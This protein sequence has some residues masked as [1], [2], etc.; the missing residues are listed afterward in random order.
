MHIVSECLGN[1]M[2]VRVGPVAG[3]LV[4]AAGNN[5]SIPITPRLASQ[6]GFSMKEDIHGTV[7]IFASLQ[8]CFAQNQEDVAFTTTL[9]ID[10][11]RDHATL[12]QYKVA[13]TCQYAAWAT[14]EILCDRNYM[15]VSVRRTT[16]DAYALPE[17]PIY[18]N[19]PSDQAA[20]AETWHSDPGMRIKSIVFHSTVHQEV[21]MTVHDAQERGYGIALTPT[22]LVLRSPSETH[23]T[24]FEDV[25]GVPMTVLRT[26]TF[27]QKKWSV[28]QID[29]QAACPTPNGGVYFTPNMITWY[30]PTFIDPLISS[31]KFNLV[32]VHMG[33]DGRRLDAAQMA[34]RQ[35]SMSVGDIYI[36]ITIPVGA[37]GGYF[38]SYVLNGQ[39]FTTYTIEPMLE[40]VWTE[41][42]T[43]ED[44]RY[45]VLFPI[46]TPM[47][48]GPIQVIDNTI[49]EEKIFKLSLGPMN[50]DVVLLNITFSNVVLSVHDLQ[51]RGFNIQQHDT[52]NGL[53]I[54]TFKVPFK[55]SVV[56][57]MGYE[58]TTVYVLHFTVGFVVVPEFSVFAQTAY[59]EA[60][61]VDI[62]PPSV[63]GDCVDERFFL[64]VRYGS[65]GFNFQ[66]LI[67]NRMLTSALAEEYGVVENG[68]HFILS[69][70][71][72]SVDAVFEGVHS[73][74]IRGRIDVALKNP[75]TNETIQDLSLSCSFPTILSECLANGTMTALAVK[76]ESVP[77]LDPM[78]LT[79]R[80]QTC[81]PT[82]S[83]DRYAYFIFTGNS[84]GTTRKFL[85]NVMVYE[86]EVSLP[87][88]LEPKD[89][90]P[91]Y[92]MKVYCYYNANSTQAVAFFVDKRKN[93]PYVETGKGMLQ[94]ALRLALDGSYTTFH[95]NE[96]YPIAKYLRQPLYFEVELK[97][98]NPQVELELENCWATLSDHKD[99]YPRW[100]LIINGC[101][102]P[103]DPYPVVFHPVWPD[104]RVQYPAHFKRFE[105]HMFA[106]ATDE[107]LS[108]PVFVHCDVVI[109]DSN[110]QMGLCNRQCS[111]QDGPLKGQRRAVS[112]EQDFRYISAGPIVLQ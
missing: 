22:R 110:N 55:D 57:Q 61:L 97:S 75:L 33:I 73:S 74:S 91:G 15:E 48:D 81:G 49:P 47:V 78:Q 99:S 60:A 80:D 9:N 11:H 100:N 67:G 5:N 86:N 104:S 101:P 71:Y 32:E 44:T 42:L 8:N 36:T 93:E 30:M 111:N 3:S 51:A 62:V 28:T 88:A 2:Q 98:A 6:C 94:I 92:E 72:T 25:A 18:G 45:K 29:A 20:H 76:L 43:N 16:Q 14:R 38:K 54:I 31:K 89:D 17:Q 27:F 35:Y 64:T 68:T 79:L 85:S 59:V 109:C 37:V 46:T 34:S 70:P 41:G 56:Q 7:M 82:I 83:N 53:K 69:V 102:N 26:S 13:E 4:I 103:V 96:D 1:V 12:E 66:T 24:Y 108:G 50:P 52:N 39:Y 65:Q 107:D 77:Y 63:S 21:A 10:L 23:E 40:L 84:C 19:K 106:F 58:R 90:S 95:R 105:V 112:S 87:D